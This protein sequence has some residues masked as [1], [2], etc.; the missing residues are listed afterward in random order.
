MGYAPNYLLCLSALRKPQGAVLPLQNRTEAG[1][2][3]PVWPASRV[4]GKRNAVA[5]GRCEIGRPSHERC[6]ADL[7]RRLTTPHCWEQLDE[8][9][10]VCVLLSYNP[11]SR[12]SRPTS[13]LL[14]SASRCGLGVRLMA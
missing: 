10:A 11:L 5:G 9:D 14:R 8:T 3:D 4:R 1:L 7:R 2:L 13:R 12:R 6:A